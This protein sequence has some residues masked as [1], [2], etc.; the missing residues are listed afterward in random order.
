MTGPPP[1]L[2]IAV[3]GLGFMGTTHLKALAG[4]AGAR[5]AAV[6]SDDPLR[7]E[8]DLTHVRGNTGGPGGSLDLSGVAKYREIDAVLAD[9]SIDAV[10]LCLPTD[11]HTPVALQALR[12][13]K[14]VLVEK[15]IAL[16]SRDAGEMADAAER[17]GRVLMAAHVLRFWPEY[18]ALHNAV[19]TGPH[20]ALRSA[21]FRRRCA[22][23]SWGGW[24]QDPGRSGGATLDLLIHDVDM[25]LHLLGMPQT[26]RATGFTGAHGL[27]C[28]DAVLEWSGGE[29]ATI[30][31]GW[32]H[33]GEFPFTMEFTA[34]FERATLDYSSA[35][36]P[37]T[38]YPRAE[39][40]H[41]P[42][43]PAADGYR[44]ELQ[45]FIDCCASGRAPELCLPRDSAAAVRLA[46]RILESRRLKGE[47]IECTK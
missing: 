4:I 38:L 37:L 14:H 6:C 32:Q 23:P 41:A 40:A 24:L 3:L 26:V 25:C 10:D 22:A 17:H 45:Y 5:I 44:D 36:R 35:S 30:S 29:R 20:G 28:I 42:P 27:D 33:P 21:E 2:R 34:T 9:G 11:L 43:L 47:I 16:S 1:P 31:G 46:E 39:P 19:Q 8:G 12:A 13:G 15:P 7:L 18:R